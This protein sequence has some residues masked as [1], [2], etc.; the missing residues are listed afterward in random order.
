M[1]E[2]I[3][4]IIIIILLL[5]I[6]L[7]YEKQ[8]S[9]LTYVESTIDKRKYLV[10]NRE[11]KLEAANLFAKINEKITIL[12]NALKKDKLF[13]RLTKKYDPNSMSESL[14]SSSYTSYS[15]NKGDKLV[16]CIRS[17]DKRQKLIDLNTI[18]F[19]AIHELAHIETKSIGHTKE[20]WDNMKVLLKVSI[21]LGIYQKIDYT[22][23]PVKYCG[24]DITNSPL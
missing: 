8:Y 20:F 13:K 10:R 23:N 15:V 11:D 14:S 9:E 1:N 5:V 21:K 6:F 7:Y 24:I 17:K 12:I 3:S 19:V 4:V 18:L 22:T 2:L 16:F